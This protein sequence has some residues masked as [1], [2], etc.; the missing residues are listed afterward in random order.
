[1]KSLGRPVNTWDTIIILVCNSKIKMLAQLEGG[2]HPTKAMSFPHW[3][4]LLLFLRCQILERVDTNI[5]KPQGTNHNT[6]ENSL[7]DIYINKSEY[8]HN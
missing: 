7:I 4:T 6:N 8:K 5:L 2:L 1:M 3:T